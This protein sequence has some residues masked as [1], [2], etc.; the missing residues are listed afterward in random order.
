MAYLLGLQESA[1]N[2]D[3]RY[4]SNAKGI[5]VVIIQRPQDDTGN[6]E[7]IEGMDDLHNMSAAGKWWGRVA[8]FIHEQ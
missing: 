1:H 4:K 7:D 3:C 5:I 8:Y 6:L 2:A